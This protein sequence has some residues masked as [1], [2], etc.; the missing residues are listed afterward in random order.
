MLC[1]VCHKVMIIVEHH[2]IELD[3]CPQCEGVWFDASE[4]ELFLEAAALKDA[5]ISPEALL[6]L[7]EVKDTPHVR[8][9]PVCRQK[10]RDVAISEPPIIIDVC[11]RGQG[12]WF[13]GGEVHR[14]L[15]Q[16]AARVPGD[17]AAQRVLD[18]LGDTFKAKK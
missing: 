5:D 14:L 15:T 6:K 2:Q 10:M 1:P 3:Y 12:L 11:R 8:K 9:C 17:D 13:D 16:M 4:L 7:P 18:F